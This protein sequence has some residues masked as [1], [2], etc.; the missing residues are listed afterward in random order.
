MDTWGLAF[1]LQCLTSPRTNLGYVQGVRISVTD[2]AALHY[3]LITDTYNFPKLAMMRRT[4]ASW[5]GEGVFCEDNR[6]RYLTHETMLD[7]A[8]QGLLATEGS[9]HQ[10]QRRIMVCLR[11]VAATCEP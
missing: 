10:R 2:K 3:V 1:T 4:L 5:V 11:L 9:I 7:V 8:F 6:S